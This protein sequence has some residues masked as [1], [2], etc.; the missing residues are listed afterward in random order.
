MHILPGTMKHLHSC[1]LKNEVFNRNS[2]IGE[3]NIWQ[4]LWGTLHNIDIQ[5]VYMHL[6]MPGGYTEPIL[7][8]I[9]RTLSIQ[10]RNHVWS[11]LW[12]DTI[13]VSFI[14]ITQNLCPC[15]QS[16]TAWWIGLDVKS[17]KQYFLLRAKFFFFKDHLPQRERTYTASL[18]LQLHALD[19]HHLCLCLLLLQ[20]S[21]VLSFLKSENSQLSVSVLVLFFIA[22]TQHRLYSAK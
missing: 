3:L 18:F 20:V 10:C 21:L 12:L 8:D 19:F 16:H 6:S 15:W 1:T 22:Q 9:S 7:P 11:L 17:C 13:T 2:D 14:Y 4:C 5:F